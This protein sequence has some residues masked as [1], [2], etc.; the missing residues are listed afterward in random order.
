MDK[1][2]TEE[3]WAEATRSAGRMLLWTLAVIVA[4][5]ALLILGV[6]DIESPTT[7]AIAVVVVAGLLAFEV[8][9]ARRELLVYTSAKGFLRLAREDWWAFERAMAELEEARIQSI[10]DDE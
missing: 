3:C 10:Y 8:L 4:C 7:R 9:A 5:L 2:E 6:P 1:A